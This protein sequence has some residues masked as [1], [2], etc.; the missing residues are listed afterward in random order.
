MVRNSRFYH[1]C[2]VSIRIA[3][4][5]GLLRVTAVQSTWKRFYAHSRTNNCVLITK[6][7]NKNS[8]LVLVEELAAALTNK[9]EQECKKIMNSMLQFFSD[10]K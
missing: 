7:G 9:R 1:V 3:F 5:Y 6:M 8:D 4:I 10:K 2:I